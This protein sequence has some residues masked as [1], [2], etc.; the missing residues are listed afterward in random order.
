MDF[1][2]L[3]AAFFIIYLIAGLFAYKQYGVHWDDGAQRDYGNANW[4]YILH[5]DKALI[6]FGDRY[7]GPALEILLI[8]VEKA[9]GLSDTREILLAHHLADFIFF[10]LSVIAFFFSAHI[11]FGHEKWAL[12]A[13]L[14]LVLS[15]RIFG[16]S[17][18]NSKDIG[19]LCAMIFS[20]YTLLKLMAK[21]DFLRLLVH[22]AATAFAIDIRILA[23]I[24]VPVSLFILLKGLFEQPALK[25]RYLLLLAL[26]P[27][28]LSG[29]TI[30]FWPI[31]WEGPWHYFY[32]ALLEM[33][34]F[35]RWPGEMLYFGHYISAT[36]L[37]WHYLPAWILLT[38]PLFFSVFWIFGAVITI[39]TLITDPISFFKGN[40]LWGAVLYLSVAPILAVILLKSVVYDS[41]RHVFFI[42]PFFVLVAVF[43]FKN[44][45]E[46]L[47]AM[48]KT[49]LTGF[50]ALYFLAMTIITI[51]LHPHQ[52]SYFNL[53]AVMC[54]TPV[55]KQFE[56]DYWGLGYR[57]GLEYI[58]RSNPDKGAIKVRSLNEP[59]VWNKDIL[60]KDERARLE[61]NR[62]S[63]DADYF[64][65]NHRLEK[66][67]V[68]P[69]GKIVHDIKKFGSSIIT[70]YSLKENE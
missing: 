17:F 10:Y 69:G 28:L 61:V 26:F 16:N 7:H 20:F 13:S 27:I 1:K 62:E 42:Y 30:L 29:F 12:M 35:L 41:W 48:P 19:F 58:L 4:N 47:S 23:I 15:P 40:F 6:G 59:G 2:K 56:M 3:S 46:R 52:N 38:T 11:L 24:M 53:A 55:E 37:P 36:H 50:T 31:L 34:R 22:C 70:V 21:P 8:G 14:M 57:Q 66:G 45:Y 49:I 64:V 43:G 65:T 51:Y 39:K 5:K 18:F 54:Y 68:P 60:K 32:T 67:Y 44:L 33:K 9:F 63:P 25:K